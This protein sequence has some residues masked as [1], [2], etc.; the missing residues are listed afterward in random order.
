[1]ITDF[2]FIPLRCLPGSPLNNIQAAAGPATLF[3]IFHTQ[4]KFGETHFT[5]LLEDPFLD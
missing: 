1:V 4:K 3:L 5:K 2:A